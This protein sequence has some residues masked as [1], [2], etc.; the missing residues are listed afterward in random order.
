MQTILH[1][2]T[3]KRCGARDEEA[4]DNDGRKA[5]EDC[6]GVYY[7]GYEEYEGHEWVCIECGFTWATIAGFVREPEVA[8]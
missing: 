8:V 7:C 1:T 3:C 4:I 5:P 6:R 2:Q